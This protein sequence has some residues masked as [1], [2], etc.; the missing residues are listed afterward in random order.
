MRKDGARHALAAIPAAIA[1]LA[2]AQ[3]ANAQALADQ[4]LNDRLTTLT[5]MVDSQQRR[6]DALERQLGRV[7]TTLV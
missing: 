6:I 1:L 3:E 7:H 2:F 5:R 4:T